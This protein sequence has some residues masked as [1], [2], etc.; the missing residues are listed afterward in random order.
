M[1]AHQSSPRPI[2][3]PE[4]APLLPA[5]KNYV[6]GVSFEGT[7]DVRVMDH[8]MALRVAVWLHRLD[9]A[10][11]GEALASESLEAGQHHQGQ[12]LESFLA[13]R[14]SSLTY[15]EVVD[16]VLTENRRAADQSL[17]HLQERRTREREAL[18]GLVKAH[19]ELD[20]ADKAAR[21]SLKKEID[22]RHKG[23]ERLKECISH[24]EAQLG[25]GPSEG[26]TP[27]GDGQI[28]HDP[29]LRRHSPSHTTLMR[30]HF[31]QVPPRP[32]CERRET[33]RPDEEG[34]VKLTPG[35]DSGATLLQGFPS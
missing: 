31:L 18:K 11:G 12:L 13:P 10:T 24:Y 16:Q 8:A 23:L 15:Q 3:P 2:L 6:P 1:S 9:M 14:M 4:A 7:R 27:G 20:R 25:Q 19:G 5:I 17:R 29:P 22:Q 32:R 21:K 33:T 34:S 28:H 30:R 35:E 26:S